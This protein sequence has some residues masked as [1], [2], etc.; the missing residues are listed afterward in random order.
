MK[1]K[2]N[3]VNLEIEVTPD[4]LKELTICVNSS[5]VKKTISII[6]NS[7]MDRLTKVLIWSD[8]P[9]KDKDLLKKINK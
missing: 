2:F 5:L 7:V 6:L 9:A 4:E 1:I 8:D 3:D